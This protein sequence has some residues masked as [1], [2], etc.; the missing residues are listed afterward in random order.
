MI[1]LEL[2]YPPSVNSYYRSP[3][4]GPLAGRTLISQKGRDYRKAASQAVLQHK[5]RKAP[6]GRL[7]VGVVLYAPDRR[8]RDID[9]PIKSLLD[10]LT[11][12]GVIEDD[13][14]IDKLAIE[15]GS[16]TKGGLV[17][18]FID[19]WSPDEHTLR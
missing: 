8:K 7:S 19:E 10:A 6:L 5:D 12:A 3:R 18:V 14:L 16:V 15:R 1:V 2:P 13:S 11:H 9:N 4:T 17:R